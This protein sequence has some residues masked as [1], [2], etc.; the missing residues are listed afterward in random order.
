MFDFLGIGTNA[1]IGN[2]FESLFFFGLSLVG[3]AALIML[4]FG[5]VM[6]LTA[7]DSADQTKRARGIMTNAIFGVA[8]A[9]LSWLILFTINP[10]LVQRLQINPAG[11]RPPVKAPITS[12]VNPSEAVKEDT[13]A[14][15]EAARK[16][17]TLKAQQDQAINSFLGQGFI[18]TAEECGGVHSLCSKYRTYAEPGS[19][20]ICV[21]GYCVYKPKK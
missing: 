20:Q 13:K 18:K 3:L 19:P 14:I 11:I 5:G 10:D 9:F 15:E 4:V 8:L 17:P 2:I 7:G 16:D 21:A 12:V 6:Y 1:N